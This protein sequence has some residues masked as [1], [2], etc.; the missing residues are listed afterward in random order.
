MLA[1]CCSNDGRTE[2]DVDLDWQSVLQQPDEVLE[3]CESLARGQKR[4]EWDRLNHENTMPV[5]PIHHVDS[6]GNF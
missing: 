1:A 5:L 2:A 3:L 6:H 4:L